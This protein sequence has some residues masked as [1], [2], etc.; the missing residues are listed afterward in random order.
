MTIGHALTYYAVPHE[1]AQRAVAR[2]ALVYSMRSQWIGPEV[3]WSLLVKAAVFC[4]LGSDDLTR[5]VVKKLGVDKFTQTLIARAVP[6][7]VGEI[8]AR[9]DWYE[10]VQLVAAYAARGDL[11]EDGVVGVLD[12]VLLIPLSQIEPTRNNED[13]VRALDVRHYKN[14][15]I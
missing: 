15:S 10:R 4:D 1:A 5:R 6:I 9:P 14:P 3:N 8:V 7:R 2:G 12:E 11:L 13:M